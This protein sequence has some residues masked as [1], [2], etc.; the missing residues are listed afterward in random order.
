MRLD[1]TC[2]AI[3]IAALAMRAASPVQAYELEVHGSYR[4]RM[5]DADRYQLADDGARAQQAGWREHRLRLTPSAKTDKLKFFGQI[6]LFS[7]QLLF[8][9][10]NSRVGEEFVLDPDRAGTKEIRVSKN[11]DGTLTDSGKTEWIPD[12]IDPR[13]LYVEYT[14]PSVGLVR[15]GQMPSDW[16]MGILANGG[17]REPL[18]GT[19][20]YGDINDRIL[21]ATKPLSKM[22]GGKFHQNFYTVAALDSVY[23]DEN[24]SVRDGDLAFQGVLAGFYREYENMSG[25]Y[26]AGRTQKD[27]CPDARTRPCAKLN[28]VAIDTYQNWMQ[29]GDVSRQQVSFEGVVLL[30]RT[31]RVLSDL[32]K[33]GAD[34]RAAGYAAGG[35]YEYLPLRLTAAVEHGYASGD[36]NPQDDTVTRLSFDPDHKV[37]MILY[38]EVLY[39]VTAHMADRVADELGATGETAETASLLG[40][41]P[42]SIA[43]LP[44]NGGVSG[45][46][47]VYPSVKY[48]YKV[49]SG[50]FTLK[51]AYLAAW[52]TSNFFDP[53]NTNQHGGVLTS[54]Y[55]IERAHS[56]LGQEINLGAEYDF[57]LLGDIGF[58]FTLQYGTYFPGDAFRQPDGSNKIQ[59][60]EDSKIDKVEGRFTLKW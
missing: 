30:G 4:L 38:D 34:V 18:F 35:S 60:A 54:P 32:A 37:G 53:L 3:L 58:R 5:L 12:V 16:G 51:A 8:G 10:H 14:N 25:L 31:T 48:D 47:Y 29:E 59:K 39:N 36:N 55:G 24:A 20:R 22:G 33:S 27:D 21:L 45:S 15:V 7:G 57:H 26:L 41:L 44:T 11:P 1:R 40:V 42:D 50:H 19:N 2:F 56:S 9:S 49:W 23:R 17:D 6:D 43:N 13:H 28:V 52:L 46:T